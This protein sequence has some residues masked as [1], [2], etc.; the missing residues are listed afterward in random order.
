MIIKG[1]QS[2]SMKL[3]ETITRYIEKIALKFKTNALN[4]QRNEDICR[5]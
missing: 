4:I 1:F 3:L 2:N 5:I